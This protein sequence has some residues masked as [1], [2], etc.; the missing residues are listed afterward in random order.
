MDFHAFVRG[1]IEVVAGILRASFLAEQLAW[2][3]N[4]AGVTAH[5]EATGAR[6]SDP[7]RVPFTGVKQI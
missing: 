4:L 6:L 7:A 5:E 3:N 1:R 2:V